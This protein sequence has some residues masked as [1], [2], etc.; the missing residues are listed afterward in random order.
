MFFVA[1]SGIAASAPSAVYGNI[2]ATCILASFP[3]LFSVS[4]YLIELLLLPLDIPSWL[5]PILLYLVY[6]DQH[7]RVVVFQCTNRRIYVYVNVYVYVYVYVNVYLYVYV[8]VYV[9]MP[10]YMYKYICM[11]MFMFMFMFM[12]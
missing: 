7:L 3:F 2:C 9:Y 12:F 4:S 11:Y 8:N 1:S 10:I 6:Y 5:F